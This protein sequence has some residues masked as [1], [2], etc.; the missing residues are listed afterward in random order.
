MKQPKIDL[1]KSRFEQ[2]LDAIGL[3]VFIGSI[4][5]LVYVFG[6]LPDE[7]PAHFNG[8]GE[9]DRWGSKMELWILPLIGGGLWL[10]MTFLSKY[11]HTFNYLNLREDNIE[12]Q[13][14]NARLMMNVLKNEIVIFFGFI[15]YQTIQ[16]AKGAEEGLGIA[17]LPVF[18][19][20]IL[21]ST[22]YF[23]FRMLKL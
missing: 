12:A 20:V 17:F 13:Y 9:A 15:T 6:G 11:P 4:V 23:M 18:L 2:V 1:P 21:G 7:V 10:L 19:A 16:V 8:S 3:I 22:F 5:Y 14:Q